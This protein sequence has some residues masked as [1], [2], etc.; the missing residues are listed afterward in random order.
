MRQNVRQAAAVTVAAGPKA[1]KKW[2]FFVEMSAMPRLRL[3]SP[4]SPFPNF[5]LDG[6][7]QQRDNAARVI[8]S[9]RGFLR[10]PGPPRRNDI[11]AREVEKA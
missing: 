3:P 1:A 2:K 10:R 4:H 6:L 9:G 11:S 5:M 7:G 8:D